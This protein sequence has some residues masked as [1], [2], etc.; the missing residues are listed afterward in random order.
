[1]MMTD[2]PFL[3]CNTVTGSSLRLRAY[4]RRSRSRRA[5]IVKVLLGAIWG[6]RTIRASRLRC[7]CILWV[8]YIGV[9]LFV[10][11]N[12]DFFSDGCRR[13]GRPNA[14]QIPLTVELLRM[15]DVPFLLLCLS[16]NPSSEPCRP[17]SAN[18]SGLNPKQWD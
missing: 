11:G 8:I 18:N 12:A 3:N 10:E 13:L 6:F 16:G 4:L 2:F 9:L 1:M 15:R 5:C 7:S 14:P 17:Q